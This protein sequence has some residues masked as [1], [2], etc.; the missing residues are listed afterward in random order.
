MVARLGKP[1]GVRG[2]VTVRSERDDLSLFAPGASFET[3]AGTLVVSRVR[4][5]HGRLIMGFE[6]VD[7]RAG[8]EGLR[9]T[10][11]EA[12]RADVPL[13]TDEWWAT[14][15][16]GC[17]VVDGSGAELGV[18]AGVEEGVGQDRLVVEGPGGV[19]RIPFVGELVGEVDVPGGVVVVDVPE[20][21]WA[22][23]S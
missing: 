22:Q 21:W 15:L 18:V 13:D 8:A 12:D 10:L 9:G 20:G 1:H 7:D 17:R 3:P 23:G 6:G 16:V 2:E 19:V 14:D 4:R 11:L 5:H